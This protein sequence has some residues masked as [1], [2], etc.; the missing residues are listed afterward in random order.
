MTTNGTTSRRLRGA[1][2]TSAMRLAGAALVSAA[3]HIPVV[4]ATNDEVLRS[5]SGVSYVSGGIG[6]ESVDRLRSMERDFSVKVLCALDT[7]EYVADVKVTIVDASNRVVLDTVS[8]GPWLLVRLPPGTYQVG[9]SLGG[10]AES[11]RVTVGPGTLR[12]VDFRWPTG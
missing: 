11:R 3:L 8:E 1:P 4:S 9:A 12:T 5:A 10:R 2:R 6:T 7:G